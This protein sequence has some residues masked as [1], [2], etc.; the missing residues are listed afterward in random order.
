MS[1]KDYE[2]LLAETID[3]I[4]RLRQQDVTQD[5]RLVADLSLDSVDIAELVAEMEDH[6]DVIIPM[7]KLPEIRTVQDIALSLAPLVLT[8]NESA[9]T[10]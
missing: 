4:S 1:A 7:E 9:E 3:I 8:Q 2:T 6:F 5:T 10:V